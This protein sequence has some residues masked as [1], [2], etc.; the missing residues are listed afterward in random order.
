MI[1]DG[2]GFQTGE[3]IR[4]KEPSGSFAY[5]A[6]EGCRCMERERKLLRW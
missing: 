5:M 2:P 6:V 1:N 3:H 4:K